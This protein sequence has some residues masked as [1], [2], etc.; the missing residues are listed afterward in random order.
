MSA[1]RIKYL[2]DSERTQLLKT[3]A[4]RRSAE[5]DYMI[6][7]L[8]LNTGLRLSEL[9]ALNI[10][11]VAG[12]KIEKTLVVRNGKG[13]KTREVPLNSSARLHLNQYLAWKAKRGE[14]IQ[15]D[16]P[17]FVSRNK[18]RL[19]RRPIQRLVKKWLRQAGL[20]KDFVV[21]SLRHSFATR[22]YQRSHNIRAVQELLGH[23]RLD[24]TMIY[25]GIG[26]E[27]LSQTVELLNAV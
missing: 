22:L 27:E 14:G 12:E 5:R 8:F 18:L 26:K 17:L 23:N 6:I 4:D 1:Q 16:D 7:D 11:D 13:G 19:S 21:H 3:L 15:P 25:T 20:R 2:D 9:H 24:T 10:S